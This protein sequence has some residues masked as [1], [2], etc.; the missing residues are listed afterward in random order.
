MAI[1]RLSG[2]GCLELVRP[3]FRSSR[4]FD[5]PCSHFLYHGH[6]CDADGN[7]L[8]EVMFVY[9]Q[10]P[11]SFTAEDVVE[12][13]CH[14]GYQ[15][16]QRILTCL[17]GAGARLARPG[18][19]SYRAYLNGRLDLSQAEAIADLIHARS[20]VA[21]S[22][23][24]AQLDGQISK[25]LHAS[26]RKIRDMLALIEAWIDF[27]E[28]ELPDEDLLEIRNTAMDVRQFLETMVD[29]FNTGRLYAE[30]VSL[31]L[32]GKPNVGKSSLMNA[33]L[34]EDR[35]IVTDIAGTTRDLLEEGLV[36]NGL[37]VRLIDSAGL[38]DSADPVERVG[39]GRARAKIATSDLVLLLMDGSCPCTDEDLVALDSCANTRSLIVL[40]KAD[41]K[42][43]F[44][45][46][47]HH[48]R[49]MISVSV[50]TGEGLD[51]LRQQ[52]HDV[53][54]GDGTRADSSVLLT[55]QRHQAA[56]RKASE[57][58]ACF[59]AAL[60]DGL[61]LEFLATDLHESLYCLGDITGETTSDDVLE[62]IFSRFC[63]GK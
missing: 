10:A 44:E 5:Q 18:E 7:L 24:V 11:R 38:R 59:V 15:T 54:V 37:P 52:I 45:L 61:S 1:V 34:G 22:L 20:E 17:I 29:S 58:L 62:S 63:I 60:D 3:F 35:A 42:T 51:L 48:Q 36:I 2:K 32:L 57:A 14:G 56:A 31:L 39:V 26:T 16:V 49:D 23:A 6:L 28:E 40:T 43:Q 47:N 46:P 4:Y 33:L 8:D 50:R 41:L 53:L 12:V 13:H 9:M 55:N 30:G 25:C 27:P 19:F 21:Q